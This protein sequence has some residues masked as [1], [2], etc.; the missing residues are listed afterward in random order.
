[1]AQHAIALL[2]GCEIADPSKL[3]S[4]ALGFSV[5]GRLLF[6]LLADGFTRRGLMA[7]SLLLHVLGLG[8]VFFIADTNSLVWLFIILY[9]IGM[10]GFGV[11]FPIFLGE[12]FGIEHFSKLYGTVMLFQA[13]GLSVGALLFGRTF[14]T[15][16]SYEI[17]MQAVIILSV[18]CVF[19]TMII[20]K[21]RRENILR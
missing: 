3:W 15:T 10:G 18:L 4:I 20:R 9:G 14:D 19:L 11:L 13:L 7:I 2:R 21:P 16:G 8:S 1:M 17:A 12:L 6:G 5:L